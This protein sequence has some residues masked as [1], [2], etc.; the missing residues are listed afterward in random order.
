MAK[1]SS[2]ITRMHHEPAAAAKASPCNR[3]LSPAS[4]GFFFAKKFPSRCN[5]SSLRPL[6]LENTFYMIY[7]SIILFAIAALLG[8]I[9]LVK[10]LN[11]KEAS[12][13]VVYLH[14]LGAAVALVLLV[15]FAVQNP[16]NYPL[17]SLVLFV[18]AALGGF[19]MFIRDL[20]KKY[21]PMGVAFLHALLAVGGF[22]ALLIFAI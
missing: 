2:F 1:A 7:A 20:K 3:T 10:W 4:A 14:G 13:T 16:D 22:L 8:V 6:Y 18:L 15:L 11:K 12:R 21:S 17:L 9:I 5:L 19:Y